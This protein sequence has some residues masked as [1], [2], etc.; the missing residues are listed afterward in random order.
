MKREDIDFKKDCQKYHDSIRR[1][2]KQG[3]VIE[4][5]EL[6]SKVA[7]CL[8]KWQEH[9]RSVHIKINALKSLYAVITVEQRRAIAK[10]ESVK[11]IS[12][13]REIEEKREAEEKERKTVKTGGDKNNEF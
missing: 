1:L 2:L 13:M 11:K 6:I 8:Q 5:N 10:E 4:S 7:S 12:K 9:Q 3:K